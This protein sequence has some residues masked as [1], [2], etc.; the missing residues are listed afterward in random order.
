MATTRDTTT[1][2]IEVDGGAARMDK[3]GQMLGPHGVNIVLALQAVNAATAGHAGLRV[4][5]DLDIGPDRSVAVRA[6]TPTTASLLRRAAGIGRGASSPNGTPVATID[7]A[8]LREIART[9]L[10]DLPTD[11][12]EAA[13]RTVAGT[14]RSMG[15]AV[16]D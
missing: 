14:A 5:V 7:A 12:V 8:A 3:L 6:R 15:I 16:V 2:R 1:L 10:P 4:P 13:A 11:D 9:K